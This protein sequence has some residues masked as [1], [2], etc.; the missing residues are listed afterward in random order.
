MEEQIQHPVPLPGPRLSVATHAQ[1]KPA[2]FSKVPESKYGV[3][4]D[5]SVARVRAGVGVGG[6]SRSGGL[7]GCRVPKCT[8]FDLSAASRYCLRHRICEN[9]LKSLSV[10]FD[11]KSHRFCQKCTRFHA[12]QEFD[13]LKHSCRAALQLRKHRL[14]TKKLQ[15]KEQ[16]PQDGEQPAAKVQRVNKYQISVKAKKEEFDLKFP[17]ATQLGLDGAVGSSSA[18]SSRYQADPTHSPAVAAS[19]AAGRGVWTQF[20][21]GAGSTR[22]QQPLRPKPIGDT[23]GLHLGAPARPSPDVAAAWLAA[24]CS[25]P[26][27]A[28]WVP[29]AAAR[30][31]PPPNPAGLPTSELSALL[32]S[33]LAGNP[34]AQM[35]TAAMLAASASAPSRAHPHHNPHD[36]YGP[37]PG[38]EEAASLAAAAAEY[39][40]AVGTFALGRVGGVDYS[41]MPAATDRPQ[42]PTTS[43]PTPASASSGSPG[44]A[45][46]SLSNLASALS[47]VMPSSN[48]AAPEP[49]SSPDVAGLLAQMAAAAHAQAGVSGSWPVAQA[50]K[51]APSQAQHQAELLRQ[52][53]ESY[54]T[55]THHAPEAKTAIPARR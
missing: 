27:P 31:A 32:C 44:M 49:Q 46:T 8:V 3:T 21:G 28:P 4:V 55:P 30:H 14:H 45:S 1:V 20:A 12:V 40:R 25:Q 16:Q 41:S 33:L 10:M 22:P 26:P 36:P 35:A 39:A 2:V 7:K 47:Q 19:L 18:I 52:L 13:N 15:E 29:P 50:P 23:L 17:Q 34:Q 11:D 6:H 42:Y 37:Q 9:H 48:V 38:A 54:S 43:S 53:L 5:T 51:P 24:Q